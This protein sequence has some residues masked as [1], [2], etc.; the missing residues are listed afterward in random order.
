MCDAAKELKQTAKFNKKHLK[1]CSI[2]TKI[3]NDSYAM[4]ISG[5]GEKSVRLSLFISY[6]DLIKYK[7]HRKLEK[8]IYDKI[9]TVYHSKGKGTVWRVNK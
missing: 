5:I 2:I 8:M 1:G 3:N 4:Q 9:N 6:D 7:N